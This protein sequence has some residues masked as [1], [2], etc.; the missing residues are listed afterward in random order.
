MTD[1]RPRIRPVI[2]N[3]DEAVVEFDLV[4][5]IYRG[6]L[7]GLNGQTEWNERPHCGR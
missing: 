1:R 3:G 5:G 6:K 7:R 4:T 2:I